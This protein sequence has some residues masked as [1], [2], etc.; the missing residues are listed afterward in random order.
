MRTARLQDTVGGDS[1][2]EHGEISMGPQ[3]DQDGVR[4]KGEHDSSSGESCKK[5]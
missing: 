4:A 5:V 3:P 2:A 1:G